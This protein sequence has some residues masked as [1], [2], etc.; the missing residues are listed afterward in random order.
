MGAQV[1]PYI[2]PTSPLAPLY[3]P[4]MGAQ[5]LTH[6][7]GIGRAHTLAAHGIGRA[8]TLARLGRQPHARSGAGR[9]RSSRG[10][11][12]GAGR[13]QRVCTPPRTRAAGVPRDRGGL[14]RGGRRLHRRAR[15]PGLLAPRRPG[16]PSS[17]HPVLPAPRPPG[18]PPSRQRQAWPPY[19]S[20]QPRTPAR[21]PSAPQGS[22]AAAWPHAGPRWSL[23]GEHRPRG[24]PRAAFV[25]AGVPV[26]V[27]VL[28]GQAPPGSLASQD[29]QLPVA[30]AQEVVVL[31]QPAGAPPNDEMAR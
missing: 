10:V 22:A 7:H 20:R 15:H 27:V 24:E 1:P 13:A 8:R 18:T 14:D 31:G 17:R 2:S 5:V 26:D 12:C 9:E 25:C 11:R 3:L 30:E 4:Y 6:T 21:R 19:G 16:T 28:A 23:L 29:H